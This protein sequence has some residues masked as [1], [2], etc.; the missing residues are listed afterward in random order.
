MLS[1]KCEKSYKSLL[2]ISFHTEKSVS[3]GRILWQTMSDI[4]IVFNL[5]LCRQLCKNEYGS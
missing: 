3:D 4:S 5:K 2:K 1:H